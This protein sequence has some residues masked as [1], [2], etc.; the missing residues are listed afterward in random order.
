[1]ARKGPY[2]ERA[3]FG[4]GKSSGSTDTAS[5]ARTGGLENKTSDKAS[6]A[7]AAMRN[8]LAPVLIHLFMADP[9]AVVPDARS[10]DTGTGQ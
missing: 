6:P 9:P 5:A 2:A 10:S 4:A 3:A 7:A 8:L 1:M